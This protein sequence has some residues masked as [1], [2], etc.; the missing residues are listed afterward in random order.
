M[1][2]FPTKTNFLSLVKTKAFHLQGLRSKYSTIPYRGHTS[3]I[4]WEINIL[5]LL[6]IIARS[7]I[8]A[9]CTLD[10]CNLFLNPWK[11]ANLAASFTEF[12]F[13]NYAKLAWPKPGN[14]EGNC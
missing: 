4:N 9:K 10:S 11:K 7:P 13:K 6:K 1:S 2:S 5:L 12:C 8:E 3:E 14:M